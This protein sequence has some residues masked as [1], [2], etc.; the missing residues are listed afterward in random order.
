MF[1]SHGRGKKTLHEN[2]LKR[3]FIPQFDNEQVMKSETQLYR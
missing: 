1:P 2:Q 3:D